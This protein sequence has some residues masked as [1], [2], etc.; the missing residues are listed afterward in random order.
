MELINPTSPESTYQKIA[1]ELLVSIRGAKT[2]RE[3]SEELGYS[4][5]QVGKWESGATRL[6]WDEF[7][8]MSHRLGLNADDHLSYFFCAEDFMPDP[9]VDTDPAWVRSLKIVYHIFASENL[10][11]PKKTMKRWENGD[12]APALADVLRMLDSRPALMLGWLTRF[13]DCSKVPSLEEK[14]DQLVSRID[15]VAEDPICVY[16]NAALKLD[17]YRNLARHDDKVL[18]E[19]ATC[20]IE[21]LHQVLK[22]MLSHEIISFDGFKYQPCP[23]DFSFSSSRNLK[24]RTLTK[25]TTELAAKRYPLLPVPQPPGKMRNGARGSVRVTAVS[26][27]ASNE[28]QDLILK[29]HNDVAQVIAHDRDEKTGVQI[30]LVHSFPSNFNSPEF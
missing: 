22:K 20:S 28:I 10:P 2:Q 12:S 14:L 8:D 18:C 29:F 7:I 11:W 26:V 21:E 23:F 19:H 6:K 4:F 9:A 5:N 30:V 27:K 3:L 1:E 25:Y 17:V 16:V 13:V 15:L 24:I